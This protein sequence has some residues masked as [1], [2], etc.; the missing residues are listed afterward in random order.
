MRVHNLQSVFSSPGVSGT[1]FRVQSSRVHGLEF[2]VQGLGRRIFHG[3]LG[4]GVGGSGFRVHLGRKVDIR[5]P[6][7]GNSNSHGARSVY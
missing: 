5:L 1:G 6:G 7:E 2:G 3:R 4:I